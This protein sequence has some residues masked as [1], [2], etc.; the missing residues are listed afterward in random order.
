MQ[1]YNTDIISKLTALVDKKVIQVARYIPS[2][3]TSTD[4]NMLQQQ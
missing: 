1:C 4:N 3:V 2:S